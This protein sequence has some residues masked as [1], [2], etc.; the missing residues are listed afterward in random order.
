MANE[1]FF[2]SRPS[3]KHGATINILQNHMMECGELTLS[4]R[5]DRDALSISMTVEQLQ[6]LQ[7]EIQTFLGGEVN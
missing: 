5:T 2:L 6:D 7:R 3:D 1:H 4:V